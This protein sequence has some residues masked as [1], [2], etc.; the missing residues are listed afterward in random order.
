MLLC[1]TVA[2]FTS[3]AQTGTA[4]S[5]NFKTISAGPQYAKSGFYQWLWG[6]N[7]RKEWITPVTLPTI[8]LDTLRGGLISFKEGGSNQSKSLQ[9]K[10]QGGEYALRSV[11]KSLS[12][13]IPDIFEKTFVASIVNDAISMSNPYGALGVAVMADAAGILHAKPKYYYL[14]AQKSLDS[15]NAK[16]AGKVYLLEERPKGDWSSSDN[17]G[18][19]TDFKDLEDMLPSIL[20]DP[21]FSVD[22][23]A[24]ARARLLDIMIGDFDRHGDQWKWGVKKEADKTILVPIP[25]DRD[26]AFSTRNGLLLDLVVRL[27]GLKFIQKFHYKVDNVE[28]LAQV[29]RFLDRIVTNKL[30][31]S[32]WQTIAKD[33]QTQVTDGVIEASVKNMPPEIF[34]IRGA[35]LIAKLKSRRDDLVKY[36]TT[37]YRLLAEESEIVGTKKDDYFEINHLPENSTE[38]KIFQMDAN[39]Q[40]QAS[41][42]YSR[43][44]NE[45]ET[46]EVRLYGIGGNDKY[47]ITGK[48]NEEIDLRIIGGPDKDSVIDNSVAN[49]NRKTQVYD[50]A[51]NYFSSLS[52]INTHLSEDSAINVYD[53]NAFKPDRKG[54]VPHL[55]YNDDD[56]IFIGARYQVLNNRWHKTP[57]AYKQSFDVDYSIT[58]QAFSTTYN[59]LFP[60]LFGKWDL[61]TRANFDWVRWINFY[62]LGNETP[63]ITNNREFYRM[64]SQDG[65][66]NIGLGRRAGKNNFHI[67]GFYQRVKIIKDTARFVSK[68]VAPNIPGIFTPD[69]F[70][71]LQVNYDFADVKDSVLPQKGIT[72][73]LN[74]KHT[75][76][77]ESNDKSFQRYTGAIQFF[78]PLLPKFSIA[79]KTGGS[80]IS[81]TPEFYQ[82]PSIGE[83]YNLR[84]F[85]R[86]RFTGKSTL[87]NNTELRYIKKVRSYLFNGKAGLMAFVDNGKVWMPGDKSDKI[88]TTLGGGIL[89]APFN[90][91]SA[92][93]TV[94][95]SDEL[96]MLQFRLGVLF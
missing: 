86:E 76:N 93:I 55:I 11:D 60:T 74:A 87:Y 94:G 5:V 8:Y 20:K 32:D 21:N 61:I 70:A 84:G 15:L 34:A 26:Q 88:H 27:A 45:G 31:L 72:F 1:M 50:N 43:L 52:H 79:I 12:K 91:V 13:V 19:F 41:P 73:S 78:I 51:D 81:G 90:L 29:N 59:G 36:T 40:K 65:I 22:Q 14:P 6:R 46:D 53:Y 64:R 67:T 4:D 18:N 62:G 33:V 82:Y 71:G 17:L 2:S 83:S 47:V 66:V 77:L 89:L 16:Y 56:R 39:R 44:F 49:R 57:F 68:V 85:Q 10:T 9:L 58:Q 95:V 3:T 35:T 96:T 24:F 63:N 69:N 7:Y 48:L 92:A 30:T 28:A 23:K 54:L 37:Y 75:Q 38:I 80:T 42:F 25:T